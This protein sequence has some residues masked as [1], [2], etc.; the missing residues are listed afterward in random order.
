[1]LVALITFSDEI[2]LGLQGASRE[3]AGAPNCCVACVC[4]QMG[5]TAAVSDAVISAAGSPCEYDIWRQ[6]SPGIYLATEGSSDAGL[7]RQSCTTEPSSSLG[8]FRVIR[9][10]VSC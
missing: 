8:L 9:F 3:P 10:G 4:H 7:V 2:A 6:L 1:I 5:W